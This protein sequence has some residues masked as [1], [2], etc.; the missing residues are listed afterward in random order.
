MIAS[1]ISCLVATAT[2]P[3]RP[4]ERERAGVAHEDRGRRR[5]EP[6]EAK[7]RAD[8]RAAYHRE[9]AGAGHVVDLQIVG[10]HRVAGEIGDAD[11]ARRRDHH[12]ADGEAVE[13]VGQVH[14]V[15]GADDDEGAEQHEEPA[16][17]DDHFLEHRKRQR[18]RELRAAE[19][20]E[21][22]AGGDRDDGFDRQPQRAAEARGG[23]LRHLQIVVIEAD[24]AEAERHARARSR[25][26]GCAGWPTARSTPRCRAGSSARP[27][28]AC[29]P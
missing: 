23:L 5:V 26:R 8:H 16:E 25:R 1:A 21:R 2:V 10:E 18:G 3:I 29:R 6:E 14:R 19:V 13:P 12:R 22:D 20:G 9:L 7:P 24:Q 4:A 28:S 15:A 11:E 17:I 27:W